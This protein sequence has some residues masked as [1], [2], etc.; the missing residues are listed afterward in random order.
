MTLP[1][2][3]WDMGKRERKLVLLEFMAE[4]G[5][6]LPPKAIYR[7][8]RLLEGITFSERSIENYLDEFV[9]E[10]LVNRIDPERMEDA[11]IAEIQP[12]ENQ[13]RAYYII[14]DKGRAVASD[15]SD[16]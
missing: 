1:M 12:G 6:A 3:S 4:Y 13:R 8:L 11:E 16:Y 9:A 7:N 2:N 10:S 14:T 15:P 5:L